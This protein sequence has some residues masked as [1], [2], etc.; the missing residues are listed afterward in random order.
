MDEVIIDFHVHPKRGGKIVI[1]ELVKEFDKYGVSKAVILGR[2]SDPKNL[3]K[4]EIRNRLIT[5]LLTSP[6]LAPVYGRNPEEILAFADRLGR[7]LARQTTNVEVAKCVNMHPD[8][9]IGLGSIDLPKG[10]EHVKQKLKEIHQLGLKGI[11]LHPQTGFFNP[12]KSENLRIICEDFEKTK[13]MIMFHT[14]C[15]PGIWESPELSEYANPKYLEPLA[16][17]FDVPLICAH[18]GSY[19]N[20]NPGIWFNEAVELCRKYDNTWCDISAVPYVLA[21][22]AMVN[23]I[24]DAK[25]TDRVLFGSDY[26]DYI[27]FTIDTVKITPYLS[28]EEKLDV[29]GRNAKS[30]LKSVNAY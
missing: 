2:E 23:K 10:E 25:I 3:E 12:A 20:L 15:M 13:K 29:L 1:D 9:I 5:L 4:P 17:E 6:S 24:L 11:K 16:E 19:S 22:G 14:G 7:G 26:I 8:R 27:A 30:L 28:E 18:F 21:E